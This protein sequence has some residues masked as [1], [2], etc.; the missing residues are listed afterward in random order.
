MTG[1]EDSLNNNDI[2]F[3]P[4]AHAYLYS[5]GRVV[6]NVLESIEEDG[7]NVYTDGLKTNIFTGEIIYPNGTRKWIQELINQ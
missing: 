6:A 7:T 5:D 4:Y 3:H 1:L 2:V